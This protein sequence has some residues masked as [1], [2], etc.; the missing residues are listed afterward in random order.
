MVERLDL[1]FTGFRPEVTEKVIRLLLVL[2]RIAAH[3]F[4]GSR[5]CLHGG[6]ALNIFVLDQPRSRASRSLR[7]GRLCPRAAVRR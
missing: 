5:V 1:D 3:P 2:D 6:T 4:L 7:Q